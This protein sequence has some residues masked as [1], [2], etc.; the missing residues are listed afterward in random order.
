MNPKVENIESVTESM[1]NCAEGSYAS[2][3]LEQRPTMSNV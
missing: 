3:Q 2:L 1:D